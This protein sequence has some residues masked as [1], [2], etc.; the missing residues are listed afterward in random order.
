MNPERNT[1]NETVAAGFATHSIAPSS[2]HG[3]AMVARG[4]PASLKRSIK[5]MPATL[6]AAA[7][8]VRWIR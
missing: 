1:T 4:A 2:A 6:I 5:A 7:M 8:F 3:T